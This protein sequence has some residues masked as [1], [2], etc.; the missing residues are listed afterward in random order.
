MICAQYC[1]GRVGLGECGHGAFTKG[2]EAG[3]HLVRTLEVV[4]QCLAA[5]TLD[6]FEEIGD[7]R[8]GLRTFV[9]EVRQDCS[10]DDG[11]H[12]R[13]KVG[14]IRCCGVDD[15][16]VVAAN[17]LW[18]DTSLGT[19]VT[20]FTDRAPRQIERDV[21][22]DTDRFHVAPEFFGDRVR[23]D[24]EDLLADVVVETF[25]LVTTDSDTVEQ[26]L[27]V[28]ATLTGLR[29]VRAAHLGRGFGGEVDTERHGK[30]LISPWLLSGYSATGLGRGWMKRK[31]RF[32]NPKAS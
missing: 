6:T 3:D 25:K 16:A 1:N 18:F 2:V 23:V 15:V 17:T 31:S 32:A 9:G 28:C 22:R 27:V 7:R 26:V 20:V 21:L 11:A 30:L 24:V 14:E 19:L 8:I 10:G 12:Q 4:G 13:L 29:K 5:L